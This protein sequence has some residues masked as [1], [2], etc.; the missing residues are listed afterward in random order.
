MFVFWRIC[1][2]SICFQ[3]HLSFRKNFL[4]VE[5]Y[6][7]SNSLLESI[8]LQGNQDMRTFFFFCFFLYVCL[9]QTKF[10]YNFL[11]NYLNDLSCTYYTNLPAFR[12]NFRK[13]ERIVVNP[14]LI[15]SCL[16]QW[17]TIEYYYLLKEDSYFY[18]LFM[19]CT[20]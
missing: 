12:A 9:Q 14:L 10:S 17:V 5:F 6:L 3:F 4:L 18:R 20:V 19:K 8:N 7:M 15:Y 16:A 11:G 1:F 2:T 13:N